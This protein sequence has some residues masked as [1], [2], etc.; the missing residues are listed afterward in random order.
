MS[1]PDT[2]VAGEDAEL[3]V[4]VALTSPS[5]ALIVPAAESGALTRWPKGT[6]DWLDE[7]ETSAAG[8]LMK[9]EPEMENEAYVSGA[10]VVTVAVVEDAAEVVVG[11]VVGQI[12]L[13]HDCVS[14]KPGQATPPL[15]A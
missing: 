6:N 10:Q 12:V 11:V 8:A 4:C 2:R 13:E 7:P 9:P 1:A 3:K 15:A 5:A 14:L